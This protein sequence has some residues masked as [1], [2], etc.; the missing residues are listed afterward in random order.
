LRALPGGKDP[1]AGRGRPRS[2][3][4]KE[5]SGGV[6]AQS[7]LVKFRPCPLKTAERVGRRK[8]IK[9]RGKKKKV[10]EAI[11]RTPGDDCR[12]PMDEVKKVPDTLKKR[13]HT[14]A[15]AQKK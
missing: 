8:S 4:K 6:S 12:L 5:E 9:P 15:T 10:T 2:G 13:A 11:Y 7:S 3:T 14:S 1:D